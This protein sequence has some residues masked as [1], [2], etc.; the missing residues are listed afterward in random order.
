[1]QCWQLNQA[2]PSDSVEVCAVWYPLVSQC[3]SLGWH[4]PCRP[5]HRG[6][7]VFPREALTGSKCN[8]K[9]Q[10]LHLF[11]LGMCIGMC[12]ENYVMVRL[13]CGKHKEM[14]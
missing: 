1:M 11:G 7:D 2:A 10:D 6:V 4:Q 14:F 13:S 9:A 3:G 12:W 5:R 8:G